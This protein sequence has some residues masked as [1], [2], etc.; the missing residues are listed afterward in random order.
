LPGLAQ[1]SRVRDYREYQ[2]SQMANVQVFRDNRLT[3][4][5]VI[6]LE[7]EHLA[8]ATGAHWRRDGVSR[9]HVKP[10][11]DDG[12][13]VVYTP[14][15]IMADACPT[16]NV[17][18]FDDDHYYMGS[19][20]AERLQQAGCAVTIATPSAY[21]AEWTLNTLEQ[22]FIQQRLVDSGVEL[23]VSTTLLAIDQGRVRLST[24]TQKDHNMVAFDAIVQ[25]TSKSPDNA[26]FQDLQSRQPEWAEA[27]IKSVSIIGDAEAPAPIAWATYAGHRYARQLDAVDVGDALPFK[28]EVTLLK[29]V[30]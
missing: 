19:V 17:L 26:L 29:T 5:D 2:I 24:S 14:D 21:V 15:D 27:G 3:A 4:D 30:T 13:I 12:S 11:P 25:V 22:E 6:G 9:Y 10:M 28:R 20:I 8:V 18:V 23:R 1:W 7:I 16:G